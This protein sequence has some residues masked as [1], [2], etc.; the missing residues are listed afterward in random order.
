MLFVITHKAVPLNRLVVTM[1]GKHFRILLL[2]SGVGQAIWGWAWSNQFLIWVG[3]LMAVIGLVA[4]I[5]GEE[6]EK[7]RVPR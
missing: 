5:R 6:K 7:R 4:L 2:W 1:F 3:V